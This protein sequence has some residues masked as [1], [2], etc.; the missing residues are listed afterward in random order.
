MA[1]P[2]AFGSFP[3]AE[4]RWLQFS[5]NVFPLTLWKGNRIYTVFLLELFPS[6]SNTT[7]RSSFSFWRLCFDPSLITSKSFCHRAWISGAHTYSP[8]LW[9]LPPAPRGPCR[10]SRAPVLLRGVCSAHAG[11]CVRHAGQCVYVTPGSVCTSRRAVC[12]SRWAVYTSRREVCVH[13]AGQCTHH[14]GQCT[15]HAGKCVRHTGWCVRHAGR[16]VRHTRQCIRYT[17][18]HIHHAGWLFV[19]LGSVYLTPGSVYV[20]SGSV[21]VTPGGVYLTLGGVYATPGSVYASGLNSQF[22]PLFP[23]QVHKPLL[24]VCLSVPA[25]ANRLICIIFLDSTHSRSYM[26]FLFFI[27]DLSFPISFGDSSFF[28]QPWFCGASPFFIS[29]SRIFLSTR[30]LYI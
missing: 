7:V 5:L 18:R 15:R 17:G 9:G 2:G 24:K 26:M 21:Y 22:A 29:F 12:T 14:A 25:P 27:I 16:C 1:R 23:S 19:A 8:S 3:C 4:P 11:Q 28:S 30:F 6:A 20:T 13:H 10:A